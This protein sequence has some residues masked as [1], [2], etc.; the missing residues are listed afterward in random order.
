MQKLNEY[1]DLALKK[2]G[3]TI[4]AGKWS[5]AGLVELIKLCGEYLNIQTIP[6]Y[7][8]QNG[9]SYQGAKKDT[10]NRKNIEIFNVKF[11]IDNE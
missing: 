4:Q 7:C 2:L 5:N 11:I 9:I 3:E 10:K 6:D 1:E 8:E